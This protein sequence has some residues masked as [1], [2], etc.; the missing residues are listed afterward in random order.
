MLL[1]A[2]T[3]LAILRAKA[4]QPERLA[5]KEKDASSRLML[6]YRAI[7][8]L[9]AFESIEPQGGESPVAFAGRVVKAGEAPAALIDVARAVSLAAYSAQEPDERTFSQ[10]AMTYRTLESQMKKTARA[11]YALRRMLKGIGDYRQIP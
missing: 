9:L 7:L 5:Q 8:S 1:A 3:C 6:W 10:A 4:T 11:R 2:L